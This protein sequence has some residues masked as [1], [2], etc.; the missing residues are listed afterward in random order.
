MTTAADEII[1]AAAATGGRGLER[2]QGEHVCA[3]CGTHFVGAF[4]PSCGQRA[5]D[6]RRPLISFIA[7]AV[8]DFFA[9]DARWLRTFRA[10]ALRPGKLAAAYASGQRARFTPPTRTFI[11]TL[12]TVLIVTSITSMVSENAN[13]PSQVAQE[14]PEELRS[15]AEAVFQRAHASLSRLMALTD[16]DGDAELERART[17]LSDAATEYL[18][19]EF[20]PET[21]VSLNVENQTVV[22]GEAVELSP[23]EQQQIEE[24][25]QLADNLPEWLTPFGDRIEAGAYGV[26][27]EPQRF[28]DR[29]FQWVPRL[30]TVMAFVL[31][32]L[33]ALVFWRRYLSEHLIFS[34]YIHSGVATFATIASIMASIPYVEIIGLGLFLF[35]PF[36]IGAA[37]R[38]FYGTGRFFTILR[39]MFVGVVYLIIFALG[40][41]S[42][43]LHEALRLSAV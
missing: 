5:S 39:M 42:V 31:A 11:F 8:G 40:F 17:A 19:E 15:R 26:A 6:V 30:F 21:A 10:L 24:A 22:Q 13:E 25:R 33:S 32:P 23:E 37:M 29:L 3:N 38:Q 34:L 43:A 9:L 2:D 28:V 7:D 4:C 20:E 41:A 18:G 1:A 35:I 36:Y 27:A 14:T 16:E 12:L